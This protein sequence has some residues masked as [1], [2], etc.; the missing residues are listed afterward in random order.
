MEENVDFDLVLLRMKQGN[1][2]R[3]IKNMNSFLNDLKCISPMSPYAAIN[4]I[5][6][7]VGYDVYIYS[8]CRK[9]GIDSELFMSILD[10][11]QDSSRN[12]STLEQW[13]NMVSDDT[14]SDGTN[15]SSKYS[16]KSMP[17]NCTADS[18]S[19]VNICTMHS[20]KGLEYERVIIIDANEGIT[21]YNKAVSKEEI[22]EERRLFYVAMTRAKRNL[23]ICSVKR[24]NNKMLLP[25]RFVKEI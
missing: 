24:R 23:I 19:N 18:V 3:L 1:Q 21:P 16:Q 14:V 9:E 17:D 2:D 4:Y 13:I 25:S 11:L 22:E 20:S 6:K 10:R 7:K 15:C 12:C 5:R 8:Y